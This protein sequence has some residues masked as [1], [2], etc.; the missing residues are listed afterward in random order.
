MN[1]DL[2]PRQWLVLETLAERMKGVRVIGWDF[3]QHGPIL[4]NGSS[5]HV[6]LNRR[7]N[8]VPR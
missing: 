3:D 8:L 6:T 1:T 4:A 2:T 7:G 5:Q